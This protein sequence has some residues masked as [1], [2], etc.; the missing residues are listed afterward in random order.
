MMRWEGK[1]QIGQLHG[2]AL[3]LLIADRQPLMRAAL[4][5]LL[6]A[7]GHQIVAEVGDGPD[8]MEALDR[9]QVDV[10]LIDIDLEIPDL[11]ALGAV[12]GIGRNAIAV[13][14]LAPSLEHLKLAAAIASGIAGLVLKS[15]SVDLLRLCLGT[16]AAGGRW[17]DR[18]AMAQVVERQQAQNETNP[19]TR[20]ERDVAR[21]VATGQRNRT[22]ADT[23][24]ISQ[25][26]VKMHL[27]NIFAKMGLE[28]RTQLAMDVRLR[29]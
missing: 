12:P 4:A 1:G 19:L 11:V 26:T 14:G 20:R 7:D 13:I 28:S 22:I 9:H 25:G 10:A 2:P 16:V 29:N 15:E 8:L 27:H 6:T 17:I 23:L 18:T 24:G 3:R 21:L 5:A